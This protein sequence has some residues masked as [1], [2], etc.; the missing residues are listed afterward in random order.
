MKMKL[1][2]YFIILVVLFILLF[3]NMFAYKFANNR[4]EEQTKYVI[5]NYLKDNYNHN[6]FSY[7][8]IKATM[9]EDASINVFIKY[10]KKKYRFIFEINGGYKL[11]DVN[12]DIPSYIK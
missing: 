1:K 10:D 3:Y 5:T 6:S 8:Y 12:T 9:N 11:L 7:E 2:N 4:I